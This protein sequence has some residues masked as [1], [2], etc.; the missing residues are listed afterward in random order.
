MLVRLLDTP[1]EGRCGADLM[2]S[3][4][5]PS[6]TLYPILLRFESDGV[7]TSEWESMDPRTLGHPR[8]RFYRLT[9][10]G[11]AV[12]RRLVDELFPRGL[13]VAESVA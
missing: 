7:L 2:R 13:R 8:R 10:N 11:Y 5:L 4:R 1:R 12:A 6:G 3:T 9:P